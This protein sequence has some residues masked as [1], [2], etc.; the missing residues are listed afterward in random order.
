MKDRDSVIGALE[1]HATLC[2]ELL[3]ERDAEIARLREALDNSTKARGVDYANYFFQRGGLESQLKRYH[4]ALEQYAN[5]G[6]WICT[7]DGSMQEDA[8][9]TCGLDVWVKDESEGW[10]LADRALKEG[11]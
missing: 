4:D 11:K 1:N 5:R 6:N 8:N 3:A 2:D 9:H 10:E 7:C